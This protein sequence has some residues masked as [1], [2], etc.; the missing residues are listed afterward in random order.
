MSIIFMQYALIKKIGIWSE[1]NIQ[2]ACEICILST[3][4]RLRP[5]FRSLTETLQ[6]IIIIVK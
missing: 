3:L 5:I 2:N 1:K 4:S 6:S